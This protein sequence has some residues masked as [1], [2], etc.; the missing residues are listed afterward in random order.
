M[1]KVQQQKSQAPEPKTETKTPSVSPQNTTND[2]EIEKLRTEN[3]ALQNSLRMRDARDELKRSLIEAGAR[4][5]DLLF[6]AAKDGLQFSDEGKLQNAAALIGHLK[7]T[8]PDQFGF[9][10]P[11]ASIDGGAGT[12]LSAQ[13]LTAASL[14]KMTPAQIQK[15]N[16]DDVRHAMSER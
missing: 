16:W 13:P 3:T 7:L 8:F 9:Q 12:L 2:L 4:S 6:A 14:S 1:D 5:P 15:L 11:E 10:K